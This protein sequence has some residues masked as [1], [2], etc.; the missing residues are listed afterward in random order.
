MRGG[1]DKQTKE[2]IDK[3][4]A[5]SGKESLKYGASFY[6][7]VLQK[8]AKLFLSAWVLDKSKA[9]RERGIMIEIALQKFETPRYTV[10][11]RIKIVFPADTR[12]DLINLCVIY[13]LLT[14]QAIMISSRT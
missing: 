8:V 7:A 4:A 14:L 3:E 10:T 13:S 11:V 6:I 2:K 12:I 9:E 1:I 5:E